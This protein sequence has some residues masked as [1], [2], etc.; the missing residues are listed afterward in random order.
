MTYAE[1]T[2]LVKSDL[3]RY[4]GKVTTRAGLK[5]WITNPGFRYT[6][7]MRLCAY[8]DQPYA[9]RLLLPLARLMLIRYK[10]KY[11]ISI[12]HRTR[13]GSG[14]YIGHFGGIIVNIGAVIG[15]NCNLSQGVTI[16][17][18]NRGARRGVPVIGD[19]VFI[20]PGAVVLGKITIGNNVAIGANSVVTRD[21][22]DG[23][24]VV[25]APAQIISSDGVDGYI[26]HTDYDRIAGMGRAPA[27]LKGDPA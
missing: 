19:N 2:Y 4:S 6:F 21:V 5:Y 24:V 8:L 16:G 15:K 11:G 27:A 22:P 13:I 26:E 23:A 1:L 20:G 12:G 9:L 10:F 7:W 3:Y 25:G 14:L 17:Q 18:A